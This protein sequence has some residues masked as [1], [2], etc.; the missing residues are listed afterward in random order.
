MLSTLKMESF[1]SS[2]VLD[3][4]IP[5]SPIAEIIIVKYGDRLSLKK[6][7]YFNEELNDAE[8]KDSSFSIDFSTIMSRI[9]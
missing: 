8:I 9:A 5:S 3:C 4:L 7:N 6:L 2:P 1:K